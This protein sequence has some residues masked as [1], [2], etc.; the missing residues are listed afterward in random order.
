MTQM[1]ALLKITMINMLRDLMGKGI[2]MQT[3]I[4]NTGRE[5][6]ILRNS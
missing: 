6:K 5:I 2:N 1:L 4:G 3:Q